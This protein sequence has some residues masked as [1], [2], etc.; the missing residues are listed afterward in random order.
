MHSQSQ[1]A[2]QGREKRGREEREEGGRERGVR[3]RGERVERERENGESER[4]LMLSR[5][6][7]A[8]CHCRCPQATLVPYTH[9]HNISVVIYISKGTHSSD[10]TLMLV[11]FSPYLPL[12]PP[13]SMATLPPYTSKGK[14][15]SSLSKRASI[16]M[17]VSFSRLP[18]L[19]IMPWGDSDV[20]MMS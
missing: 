10:S 11:S 7:N 9:T 12:F 17:L 8:S 2:Q 1:P 4:R 14:L 5:L 19:S 3:E 16:L 15:T 20:M 13:L 18:R 6:N